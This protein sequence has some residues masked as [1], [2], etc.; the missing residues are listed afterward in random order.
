MINIAILDDDHIFLNELSKLVD[1][2][3]TINNYAF[4]I[5]KYSNINAI[6]QTIIDKTYDIFLMDIKMNDKGDTS[7]PFGMKIN[8]INKDAQIIFITAY[9]NYLP[10]VYSC[11][12][13]YC[14]LKDELNLRLSNALKKAISNIDDRQITSLAIKNSRTTT[15]IKVNDILFLEKS[16]RK[17]IF[18]LKDNKTIETYASFDDYVNKLPNFFS[19][20]HRSYIVNVNYI[21][22]VNNSSLTMLNGKI[23]PVSK[24]YSKTIMEQFLDNFFN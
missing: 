5:D 15:I 9:P 20:V 14:I 8:N 24:T 6:N 11:N 3:L 10:E 7:I 4:K 1:D 12:H 13:I 19:K 18:T 16:L 17:I 23:I 22:S 2:Y 21:Q